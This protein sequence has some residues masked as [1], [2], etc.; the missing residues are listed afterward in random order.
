M[1]P[2]TAVPAST[3]MTWHLTQSVPAGKERRRDTTQLLITVATGSLV[4]SALDSRAHNATRPLDG[5]SFSPNS[6]QLSHNSLK[7]V[8]KNHPL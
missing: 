1:C 8:L 3:R 5:T 4:L 6:I 2:G 7:W